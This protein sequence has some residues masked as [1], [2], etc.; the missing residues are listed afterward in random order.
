MAIYAEGIKKLENINEVA[1][2]T[3]GECEAEAGNIGDWCASNWGST[4]AKETFD[5]VFE[6]A[7]SAFKDV[8][9]RLSVKTDAIL[10]MIEN[11]RKTDQ[12]EGSFAGFTFEVPKLE[13]SVPTKLSDG[14]VGKKADA[15]INDLTQYIKNIQSSV[16]TF[17][18]EAYNNA[19]TSGAFDGEEDQALVQGIGD[20]KEAISTNFETLAS[21]ASTRFSNEQEAREEAEKVNVQNATAG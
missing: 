6:V 17:L 21:S 13:N 1:E 19:S 5:E 3:G 20:M 2:T 8:K 11:Y 7:R 18:T 15:D 12:Y 10:A 16:E 9:D 4:T 14:G